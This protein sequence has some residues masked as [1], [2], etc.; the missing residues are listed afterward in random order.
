[1]TES[2]KKKPSTTH[3]ETGEPNAKPKNPSG[4]ESSKPFADGGTEP[5]S[6]SDKLADPSL[7]PT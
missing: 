7:Q 1:M 2:D 5:G 6:P 3:G 4:S